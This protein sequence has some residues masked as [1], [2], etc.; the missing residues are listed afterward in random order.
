MAAMPSIHAAYPFLG[1]LFGFRL[2]GWRAL[3]LLIYSA[4]VWLSVVYLGEHYVVDVIGGIIL[5]GAAFAA[6]GAISSWW[7]RRS[8]R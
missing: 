8:W 3:P 1:F 4:C 6:E 5:A 2:L 7:Q